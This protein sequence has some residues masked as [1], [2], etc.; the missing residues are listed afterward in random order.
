MKT[1]CLTYLVEEEYVNIFSEW[2]SEEK[3]VIRHLWV[4]KS[5]PRYLGLIEANLKASKSDWLV[6]DIVTIAD[7]LL[8]VKT[9]H[10]LRIWNM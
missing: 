9:L 10:A 5:L 2:S 1:D 7:L 3:I 6:G 8:F 4:D